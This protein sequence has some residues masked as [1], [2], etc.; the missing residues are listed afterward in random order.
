MSAQGR[1]IG[2]QA[3]ET[4]TGAAQDVAV[5]LSRF[6]LGLDTQLA[7]EPVDTKLILFQ[8][9]RA[10]SLAQQ[11]LHQGPVHPFLRGVDRKQTSRRRNGGL[12]RFK[13][14]PIDQTGQRLDSKRIQPLAFD[15]APFLECLLIQIEARQ[16]FALVQGGSPLHPLRRAVSPRG[17]QQRDIHGYG[18]G[19]ERDGAI[20]RQQD[21]ARSATDG[22]ADAQQRLP[23]TL[24]GLSLRRFAPE[25]R[26][27]L[28]P[29]MEA[30]CRDSQI[31]EQG[32][33]FSGRQRAGLVA[34]QPGRAAPEQLDM[35]IGHAG[36]PGLRHCKL[37][38]MTF[39][40]ETNEPKLLATGQK[41]T[42]GRVC[43]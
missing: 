13:R 19:I 28:F 15:G 5:E 43:M 11:Q 24:T 27:Q 8:R 31:C 18:F 37:T 23:E 22:P 40:R 25:H 30:S 42:L 20:S 2:F 6:F 26:G 16:E 1:G 34:V 36:Q 39:Q 3:V 4:G 41:P 35:E 12:G 17:F 9:G 10:L 33:G 21:R 14:L 32:L 7:L 38:G 29:R